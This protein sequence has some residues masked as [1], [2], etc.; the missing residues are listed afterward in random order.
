[1]S[2]YRSRKKIFCLISFLNCIK[3]NTKYSYLFEYI[4]FNNAEIETMKKIV[5]KFKMNNLNIGIWQSLCNCLIQSDKIIPNT[6]RKS[7]VIYFEHKKGDEFNGI[8]KFLTEKAGGNIHYKGVVEIT[9][10]SINDSSHNPKNV[11]DFQQNNLYNS[12]NEPNASICIDFKDKLI[13]LSN[14]TIKT[15]TDGPNGVNLT[16][17]ITEA[18]SDGKSW[19]KI[20]EHTDDASLFGKDIANNFKKLFVKYKNKN[21]MK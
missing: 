1:M 8:V 14:Y 17:W 6:L 11:F 9:S 19:E 2:H 20:D 12:K 21:S 15:G 16:N 3:K 4:Y 13:E 10:N 18:S 7:K 5:E